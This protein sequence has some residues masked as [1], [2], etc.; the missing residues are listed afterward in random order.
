MSPSLLYFATSKREKQGLPQ[1]AATLTIPDTKTGPMIGTAKT[2][3][4]KVLTKP[5]PI[6]CA[7][8]ASTRLA[9][10]EQRLG[11]KAKRNNMVATI[12]SITPSKAFAAAGIVPKMG[13]M[14]KL[15]RLI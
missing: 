12:N 5:L 2:L 7:L 9:V 13:T 8:N 6:C 15:D 10:V 11:I 14:V 1:L 4:T 3:P